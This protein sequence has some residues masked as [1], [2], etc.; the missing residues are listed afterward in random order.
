MGVAF[1]GES[2]G[3][4]WVLVGKLRVRDHSEDLGVEGRIRLNGSSR[5]DIRAWTGLI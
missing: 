2:R 5:S 1:M 3:A 4:Y